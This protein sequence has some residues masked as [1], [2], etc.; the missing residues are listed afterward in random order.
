MA[1]GQQVTLRNCQISQNRSGKPQVVIKSYTAIEKAK[2]KTFTINDPTTLGSPRLHIN[3]LDTLNDY[4]RV[5]LEVKVMKVNEQ[6]TV[7]TGKIKQDVIIADHTGSTTLTLW[8]NDINLLV[9]GNSYKLN[10]M[11]VHTYLSKK[12]LTLPL[13]GGTIEQIDEIQ[14]IELLQPIDE[15][16]EDTQLLNATIIAVN[17]LQTI[18]S[19]IHCKKNFESS[20]SSILICTHCGTHQKCFS[21]KTTAHL[22]ILSQNSQYTLRAYN[23]QL[24]SIAETQEMTISALLNARPFHLAFNKYHTITQVTFPDCDTS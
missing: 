10:R 11:Q 9:Q 12:L 6:I 23:D 21:F 5:T 24:K 14:N 19:C 15:A 18:T 8:Q 13:S 4:D 2:E 7:P 20:G 1:N 3:H 22:Y 17:E 16:E